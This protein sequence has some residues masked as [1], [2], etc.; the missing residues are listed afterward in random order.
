MRQCNGSAIENRVQCKAPRASPAA[1][2]AFTLRTNK[3]IALSAP[4]MVTFRASITVPTEG[5]L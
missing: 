2:W 1:P 3:S 5:S 4:R